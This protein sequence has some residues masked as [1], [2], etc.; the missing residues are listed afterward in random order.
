VAEA[1]ARAQSPSRIL[2]H[3][4]QE[5]DA[6]HIAVGESARAL[7]LGGSAERGS[8]EAAISGRCGVAIARYILALHGGTMS[9][10]HLALDLPL[11]RS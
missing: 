3:L 5:G 7:S 6:A 9:I 10:R 2:V 4:W 11:R 1:L 8:S